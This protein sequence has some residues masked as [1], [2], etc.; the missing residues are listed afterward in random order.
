[1]LWNE[2]PMIPRYVATLAIA[3]FLVTFAASS[4][5]FATRSQVL[6]GK[7]VD[8]RVQ[9]EFTIDADSRHTYAINPSV[10]FRQIS[11][12]QHGPLRHPRSDHLP[13]HLPAFPCTVRLRS[14][15]RLTLRHTAALHL[16]GVR[17]EG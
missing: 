1:M 8:E 11:E 10:S 12:R 14:I 13:G 9:L 16:L 15:G 4:L 7:A 5:Q 17:I 6:V 2:A 3:V